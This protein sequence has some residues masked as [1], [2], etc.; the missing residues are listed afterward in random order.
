MKRRK[1]RGKFSFVIKKLMAIAQHFKITAIKWNWVNETLF[2]V[3]KGM[4]L[5]G[6]LYYTVNFNFLQR[7]WLNAALVI[8]EFNLALFIHTL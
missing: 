6:T 3:H 1:F 8:A 5:Y 4:K 7:G 2:C